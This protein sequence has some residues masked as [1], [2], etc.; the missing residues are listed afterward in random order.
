[1]TKVYKSVVNPVPGSS[2]GIPKIDIQ[3]PF[4][5]LEP[6]KRHK[7]DFETACGP[8][9]CLSAGEGAGTINGDVT[10]T[11]VNH[12]ADTFGELQECKVDYSNLTCHNEFSSPNDHSHAMYEV[13]NCRN[14]LS[15]SN[16]DPCTPNGNVFNGVEIIFT[17]VSEGGVT[18]NVYDTCANGT[19]KCSHVIGG[20]HAQLKPCSFLYMYSL[21]TAE[22]KSIYKNL[23]S[24]IVDGVKV[25]DGSEKKENISYDC[26]N[27]KSIFE[28]NNNSK[29][30]KIIDS[31]LSEGYLKI[32][33]SK[34]DCIHS[35]GAVPKPDGGVRPIIDCSRPDKKSVNNY[36]S[37]IEENFTFKS[38]ENVLA[39]LQPQDFMAVI[40]IKSAY[41]AVSIH[42]DNKKIHGFEMG[43][44]KQRS[45]YRGF[46]AVFWPVPR[47][48][49]L[50]FH[51]KFYVLH[52]N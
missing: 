41:R 9:V 20:E 38:V 11:C 25:M 13:K 49:D 6:L 46:K 29:L 19:C 16:S 40:D 35:I 15:V 22:G 2:L 42:P 10:V 51:L 45:F 39:L 4:V 37:G 32:V 30:D 24:S 27:Y 21:A 47:S 50:Q 14:D 1:M 52:L 26:K 17:F 34:P 7:N 23:M 3:P 36:C 44:T 48:H 43:N 28:S 33:N 8:P 31:E 5:G 18:V 12:K